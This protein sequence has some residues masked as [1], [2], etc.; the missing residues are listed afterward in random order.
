MIIDD[1]NSQLHLDQ[2]QSYIEQIM[3]L[4][5]NEFYPIIF[6]ITLIKMNHMNSIIMVRFILYMG[7]SSAVTLPFITYR[8]ATRGSQENA[9]SPIT[10]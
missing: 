4:S 6:S 2:V 1:V 8:K 9:L 5:N 7:H 10:S 3:I